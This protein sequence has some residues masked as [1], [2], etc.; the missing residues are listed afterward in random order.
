MGAA[1]RNAEEI[2]GAAFT[3]PISQLFLA[4]FSTPLVVSGMP[5][6]WGND[7]FAPFDPV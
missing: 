7:R 2:Y 5:N 1:Y 3:S 4:S 6:S